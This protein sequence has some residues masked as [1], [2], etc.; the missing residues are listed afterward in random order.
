MLTYRVSLKKGGLT[1]K[2]NLEALNGF[3]SKSGRSETP[4]SNLILPTGRGFQ[5]SFVNC[6]MGF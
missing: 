4:C 2:A 3:K 1:F 5:V 6:R